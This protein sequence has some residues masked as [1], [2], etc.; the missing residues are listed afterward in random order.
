[1]VEIT[2]PQHPLTHRLLR[3]LAC[4]L[5]GGFISQAISCLAAYLSIS[6][7]QAAG[8]VAHIVVQQLSYYFLGCA[9][10]ILSIA[11]ILIKRGSSPLKNIRL[12]LLILMMAVAVV[13][14]LLIPRMDYLRETAL[15]D[16]MPVMLSP[17]ASYFQILNILVLMLLL[18]QIIASVLVA[19]RLAK[20]EST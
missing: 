14:F 13:S 17:F 3:F 19:W 12:P 15:I 6:D 18:T 9:F 1:M 5:A 2:R 20:S 10:A 11:N 8:M 16:G 7:S 4:I